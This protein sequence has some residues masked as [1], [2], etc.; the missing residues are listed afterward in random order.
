KIPQFNHN[1][2]KSVTSDSEIEY[3]NYEF[4]EQ[5][6]DFVE[7]LEIY[8]GQEFHT[9]DE[10]YSIIETFAHSKGFGIRKGHVEK[11]PSN[12]HEISRTFLCHHAGKRKCENKYHVS[13]FTNTH[14]GHTP[15]PTSI[16]FIPKNRKLTNE[17]L[18]DIEFYT[19]VGKIN[20]SAQ[21]QILSGKFKVP[22]KIQ[23]NLQT[24]ETQFK[25]L[26]ERYPE[27]AQYLNKVLYPDRLSWA[28]AYTFRYF[29]AG[30]QATS[31]VESINSHIKAIIH[32]GNITLYDL[33]DSLDS[34]IASQDH[35][36]DFIS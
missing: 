35:Y 31:R 34:L 25:S 5:L 7:P 13:T 28:R 24:F 17:M 3:E 10:A 4:N 12:G 14:T 1:Y 30:A 29:T 20:A 11:D 22:I 33:V 23:K 6:E 26:I 32:R 18:K 9:V 19:L 16:Q 15:D 27:A 21:Y 8:E 2:I 36:Y